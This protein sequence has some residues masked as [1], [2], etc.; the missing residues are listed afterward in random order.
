MENFQLLSD[1][2]EQ[3]QRDKGKDLDFKSAA[4]LAGFDTLVDQRRFRTQITGSRAE[5]K[6]IVREILDRQGTGRAVFR[7][8]RSAVG[9]SPERIEKLYPL[10]GSEE[11]IARANREL[12][13]ALKNEKTE[14]VFDYEHDGV[15]FYNKKISKYNF[16]THD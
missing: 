9:W 2:V 8:T 1:L 16:I 14:R 13:D 3:I 10:T 12:M 7:N 4:S 11:D 15:R 6:K 5:R